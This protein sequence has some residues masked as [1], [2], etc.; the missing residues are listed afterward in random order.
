MIINGSYFQSDNNNLQF[1]TSTLP[2]DTNIVEVVAQHRNL[3]LLKR[4]Q[5]ISQWNDADQSDVF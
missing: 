1:A 2:L 3:F 5:I 4:L